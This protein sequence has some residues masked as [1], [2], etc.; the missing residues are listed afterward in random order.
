MTEDTL[1]TLWEDAEPFPAF[2]ER[3]E[4]QRTLWDG[5][6][7]TANVPA[8]AIE[9]FGQLPGGLRLLVLNADWCMDSANTVPLLARLSEAVPGVELRLLERDRYL[10]VMDRYLTDGSR[11]IPMAILL[12]REFREL[13][14]WGPRPAPLQAWVK[15]NRK[16]I[17]RDGIIRGE[18]RWYAMDKGE[19][20][21]RELLAAA[22]R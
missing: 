3:V 6:Y 8:W 18:R 21:F 7:R 9:A 20:M 17:P 4:S 5:V 22:V 11:S 16:T 15:A 19:T 1:K 13:G 12:D 14:R 2:L 10:E